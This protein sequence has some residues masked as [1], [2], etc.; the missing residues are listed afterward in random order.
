MSRIGDLLNRLELAAKRLGVEIEEAVSILEGKH[1][2]HMVVMHATKLQTTPTP[3][4]STTSPAAWNAANSMPLAPK[5]D[6]RGHPA[7]GTAAIASGAAGQ[8]SSASDPAAVV[9]ATLM[10]HEDTGA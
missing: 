10:G 3:A 8:V 6:W 4:L 7:D 9:P 1:P 2:L 5:T